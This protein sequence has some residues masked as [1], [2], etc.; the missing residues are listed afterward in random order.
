VL[1]RSI[2]CHPYEKGISANKLS[3]VI[4]LGSGNLMNIGYFE[5]KPI[6]NFL[7]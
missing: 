2:K 1:R 7:E 3:F 5:E 4:P 6:L